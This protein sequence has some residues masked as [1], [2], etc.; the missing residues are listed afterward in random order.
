M[1][2]VAA[3]FLRSRLVPGATWGSLAYTQY[4]YLAL[5]QVAAV[6]GIW[7]LTFLVGWFASTFEM[8]W[9]RGFD[10]SVVGAPVL[11][12]CRRPR[13]GRRRR[14]GLRRVWR[15]RIARRSAWRP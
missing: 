15:R 2:L 3:E 7:G 13:N 11:D 6:V 4:G 9:S 8:A 10:W 12:L 14:R 5:M 1:A